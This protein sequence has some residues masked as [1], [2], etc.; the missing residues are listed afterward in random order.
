MEGRIEDPTGSGKRLIVNHLGWENGFLN[1]CEECFVGAKD[2]ADYHKE[3]NSIHFERWWEDSVLPRLPTKSVVVIDNAKY[4]SRQTEESRALTTNWRKAQ[5]Q[6]WL[7]KKGVDFQRKDTI[8]ILLQKSKQIKV[9][10]KYRLKEITERFCQTYRRRDIKI[11]RLP[12]GHS[13]L[14][15]IELV[16]AQL[17]SEV[18]RK[19][20]TFKIANFKCLMNNALQGVTRLNWSKDINHVLKVEDASFWKVNFGDRAP[21]VEPFIVQLKGSD[22]EAS[23]TDRDLTEDDEE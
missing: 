9:E 14:N 21:H 11:L 10:K 22:T 7:R 18:A 6:D 13:E 4:P 23:D 3:V 20:T 16:W 8:P 12:V 2:S 17:K 1:G 19:N 15:P 5:I